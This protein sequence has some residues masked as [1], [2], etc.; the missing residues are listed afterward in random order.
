MKTLFFTLMF[1]ASVMACSAQSHHYI[2]KTVEEL[3]TMTQQ[4]GSDLFFTKEVNTGKHHFLKYENMDRTKTMLFILKD[5]RCSYT[6]LM[7]DYSLLK[8]M[9]DS[10]NSNYQYQKNL[11]WRDYS[12]DEDYEYVIELNKR[13]W[14]FTIRTSRVKK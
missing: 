5:G 2:G 6:K 12:Q 8:E 13:E 14:F 9:Q 10:L 7:C 3:K 4:S 1:L 11:T